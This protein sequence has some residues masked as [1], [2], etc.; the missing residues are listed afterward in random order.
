MT[1]PGESAGAR[2]FIALLP[3]AASCRQLQ[4]YRENLAG[5]MGGAERSVRWVEPPALHLTLR[6]LGA[7]HPAQIEHFKHALLTLA[8][9]LP[10]IAARRHGIWPNRARPRLLVLELEPH[11]ALSLLA[12]ECEAHA[13]SAGF[14]PEARDF[15]AHVTLARLRPGCAFAT[16]PRATDSIR[17]EAIALMQS[18]LAH[19]G[20]SYTPLARVALSGV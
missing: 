6:F 15:R 14:A 3:D 7:S 1:L 5:A 16:L 9:A 17:F 4:R 20:A 18:K 2:C 11:A 8:T 19:S 13:R 12:R 10:P